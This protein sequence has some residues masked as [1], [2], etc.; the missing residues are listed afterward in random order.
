MAFIEN[1]PRSLEQIW[2]WIQTSLSADMPLMN[3]ESY[4]K[5]TKAISFENDR[6]VV[7]CYD[8]YGRCWLESR[9]TTIIRRMVE[10]EVGRKVQV[11]FIKLQQESAEDDAPQLEKGQEVD[12]ETEE[13]FV[14]PFYASLREAILDPNRIV[15]MP[16][17]FL[18]WLPYVGAHTIFE[19]VG[20]WQEYYL[21]SH[22]KQPK[23][24]EK[25][26]TRVERVGQWAGSVCRRSGAARRMIVE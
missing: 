15:K 23:G 25:V 16:V 18:R 8:D 4:V 3:Y 11:E 19:V 21:S 14:S 26:A 22:G 24:N 12:G 6:F 1:S 13:I 9:L 2:S 10:C 17:Y 7:G 5:P 20:L